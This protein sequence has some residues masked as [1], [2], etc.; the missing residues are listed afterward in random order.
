MVLDSCQPFPFDAS[1][2]RVCFL[3]D[4]VDYEWSSWS[5]SALI[6][7]QFE[8]L[9]DIHWTRIEPE[10]K[11]DAGKTNTMIPAAVYDATR[12]RIS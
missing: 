6:P 4:Y 9:G 7:S 11:D 5:M 12:A 1:S 2:H 8:G 3:R 10:S